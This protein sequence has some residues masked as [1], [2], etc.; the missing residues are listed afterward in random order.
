MKPVAIIGA[1]NSGLAMSAHLSL[2]KHRV[3]LWNRSYETIKSLK[4]NRIIYCD[5][6]IKG[7]AHIDVVTTDIAEALNNVETILI[8]TPANSHKEIAQRLLPHL[9]ND[10]L[11]VLNPGRTFGA[12]EFSSTLFQAGCNLALNIAET[13]TII[14]TCRKTGP[15]SVKIVAIK[16]DVLIASLK[17][18]LNP[19]IIKF[20]PKAIQKHF[21]PS[22]SMIQTSIGNVGMILHCAPT[23]LN[24]GWI[25]NPRKAFKYYYEG[26][27]PSVAQFIE[28]LDKER[29]AVSNIFEKPVE[30]TSEW[31]KRSY[32]VKGRN[33]YECIQ[34]NEAYRTID[35]P[36]SMQHRYI[37]EDIPYGLV[38]IEAIGKYFGLPMTITSLVIDLACEIMN[39]DFRENGRNLTSLGFDSLSKEEVINR[40]I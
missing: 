19:L 26:I 37:Y 1:G 21:I 3:H 33:L 6:I 31:L 8:T 23:I 25:E 18:G 16:S 2:N 15:Q 12:I 22:E 28:K 14:Y 30:S 40:L 39:V 9:R 20:L 27:T 5:G 36:N 29:I 4:R 17:S 35:A 10:M 11:I 13:Q 7:K 24:T 34:N 32:G 38:P